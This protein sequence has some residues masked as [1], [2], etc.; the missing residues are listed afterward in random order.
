MVAMVMTVTL[1]INIKS[2]FNG[3]SNFEAIV[4]QHLSFLVI[5][6]VRPTLVIFSV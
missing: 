3:V 4:L 2:E 5:L 1:M 6:R